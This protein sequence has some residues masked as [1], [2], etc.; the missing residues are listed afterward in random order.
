MVLT[1]V[2]KIYS[3]D[4]LSQVSPS[5]CIILANTGGARFQSVAI[6]SEQIL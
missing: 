4:L 3:L 6:P 5:D 2:N 1:D